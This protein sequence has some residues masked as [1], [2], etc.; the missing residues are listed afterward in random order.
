LPKIYLCELLDAN[1]YDD[2]FK[3]SNS[4]IFFQT[5]S[6][7]TP[8]LYIQ[9][10]ISNKNEKCYNLQQTI[11]YQTYVDKLLS[12]CDNSPVLFIF[13]V[14]QS[15]S[16]EG[17]PMEIVKK[18]LLLFLQSLPEGSYYQIIGFGSYFKK[19]DRTPKKYTQENIDLSILI[20]KSMKANF[21]AT[22]LYDPLEN[23]YESDSYNDI[24]LERKIFILTDGEVVEK[25]KT[26]DIIEKNRDK[27]S[28]HAIG[29]GEEFDEDLIRQAG[30]LGKGNYSFCKDFNEL[31]STIVNKINNAT[32]PC[33][34]KV[35]IESILD[36]NNIIKIGI[37]D[38]YRGNEIINLRYLKENS[39][40][41]I[42]DKI[43]VNLKIIMSNNEV[44]ENKY[45]I[46]PKE[47]NDGDELSKLIVYDSLV[48]NDKNL[49]IN[50]KIK[51]ALKYQILTDNTSLFAKVELNEKIQGELKME[52]LEEKDANVLYNKKPKDNSNNKNNDNRNNEFNTPISNTSNYNHNNRN[53]DNRPNVPLPAIN[54][55][56]NRMPIDY[57]HG[58][59]PRQ[60]KKSKIGKFFKAIGHT[61]KAILP[62]PHQSYAT[63]PDYQRYNLLSLGVPASAPPPT[64][65][66]NNLIPIAP[67]SY[68]PPPNFLGNNFSNEIYNK[69]N[70]EVNEDEKEEKEEEYEVEEI[71][72][73]EYNDTEQ[74]INGEKKDKIIYSDKDKIMEM[75]R[76]QNFIEGYWEINDKT[77]I[78]KEKYE[79]EFQLLMKL[80][81][82]NIDEKVAIT[83]LIMYYIYKEYS[84]LLNE[85]MLIIKKGKKYIN[86][87]TK[88]TYEDILKE[89]NC[90]I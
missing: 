63:P 2:L 70:E 88:I 85:L 71:E 81:N 79:K 27:F 60:E 65:P 19:Y 13:L 45:E 26:L 15:G 75:I 42:D 24:N 82:K 41:N 76:T 78:I 52:I 50:E 90:N 3:I 21:N 53:R 32:K 23:I 43:I 25:D 80:E 5:E 4:R 35:N 59:Q 30:T 57:Y 55:E 89:I 28:I 38:Y 16:M 68:P 86:K 22:N 9:N 84:G 73:N 66:S 20:I 67:P 56:N 18:A 8:K 31:N 39:N 36:D 72:I 62:I 64:F 14:D 6:N 11:S 83:I 74:T 37:P 12:K 51:M 40:I 49:D 33:I 69:K 34:K 47:I 48:S 17:E 10:Q 1:N 61:I 58:Y 29:V 54:Y 77:K 46:L 87:I 7:N 44:I